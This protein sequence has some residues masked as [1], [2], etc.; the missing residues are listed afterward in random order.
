MCSRSL[1]QL[2]K[3]GS[4]I[5]DN[6]EWYLQQIQSLIALGGSGVAVAQVVEPQEMLNELASNIRSVFAFAWRAMCVLFGVL[7]DL[8]GTVYEWLSWEAH[9]YWFF[10]MG[11]MEALNE[12]ICE[13]FG[14]RRRE[15]LLMQ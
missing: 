13:A 12:K 15:P 3:L 10:V 8:S 14:V 7:Y 6:F 4:H 11:S 1:E 2:R 9:K 5:R